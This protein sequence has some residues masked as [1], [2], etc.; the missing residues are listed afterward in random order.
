MNPRHSEYPKFKKEFWK[1]FDNLRKSERKAFYF[2]KEDI[3]E[4]NFYYKI[5][6]K[7]YEN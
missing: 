6:E 5:W 4:I 2:Y 7:L 3:A 1:W